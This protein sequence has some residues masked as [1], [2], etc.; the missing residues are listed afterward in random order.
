M[1]IVGYAC[2]SE[3]REPSARH[4]VKIK[5]WNPP[6][7]LTEVKAFLGLVVYFRIWIKN[8]RLIAEPLY[9]LSRKGVKFFW[10]RRFTTKQCKLS[11]MRYA[12]FQFYVGSITARVLER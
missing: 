1:D 6:G 9:A 8:F 5:N 7:N 12:R 11:K 2:N 10:T 4:L 3:G